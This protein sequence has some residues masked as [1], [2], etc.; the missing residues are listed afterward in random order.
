M[1]SSESIFD[2][3][4]MS[5]AERR[6]VMS[7]VVVLMVVLA[8]M[9]FT[10]ID[11]PGETNAKIVKAKNNITKFNAEIAKDA[12]YKKRIAELEGMNSA[13][14][15][16]N[17]EVDLRSKVARLKRESGL[18]IYDFGKQTSKPGDF[19]V[20]QSMRIQFNG[21]EEQIVNFLMRLG[22]DEDSLMRISRFSVSPDGQSNPTKL[23]GLATVTASYQKDYIAPPAEEAGE[24][25]AELS[26]TPEPAAN[27]VEPAKPSTEPVDAAKEKPESKPEAKPTPEPA[28]TKRRIPTRRVRTSE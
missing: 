11:D 3:Y 26:A 17:Q 12:G 21:K 18:N 23:R 20:E 5:A 22:G 25:T 24:G 2:K 8:W 28:S 14:E 27:P 4:N 10:S 7:V 6:L 19:F 16:R 15:N 9:A 1:P 13:V